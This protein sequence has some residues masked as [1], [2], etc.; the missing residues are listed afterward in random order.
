MP[1]DP[2]SFDLNA[3]REPY[4]ER[5]P[6]V[7][8]SDRVP[9]WPAYHILSEAALVAFGYSFVALRPKLLRQALRSSAMHYVGLQ[10]L[11]ESLGTANFRCQIQEA[12]AHDRAQFKRRAR[13]RLP[14]SVKRIAPLLRDVHATVGNWRS[15]DAV[16]IARMHVHARSVGLYDSAQMV[17]EKARISRRYLKTP[18]E[19]IDA[20]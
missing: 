5:R 17:L 6:N 7:V 18:A 11:I 12:L 1:F 19:A 16:D 8:F 13:H 10:L 15:A 2:T 20:D 14:R 3:F 9:C 4:S